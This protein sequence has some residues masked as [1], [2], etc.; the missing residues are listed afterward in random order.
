MIKYRVDNNTNNKKYGIQD[1]ILKGAHLKNIGAISDNKYLF[2][3]GISDFNVIKYDI[4]KQIGDISFT[5]TVHDNSNNLRVVIDYISDEPITL[6]Q[7]ESILGIL[8]ECKKTMELIDKPIRINI[9][10]KL[11]PNTHKDFIVMCPYS[12]K[13]AY[14]FEKE[15]YNL[16]D[17]DNAIQVIDDEREKLVPPIEK[18]LNNEKE[19]VLS[20]FSFIRKQK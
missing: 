12:L 11:V 17:V 16:M 8:N 3:V 15:F 18:K 6:F 1:M 10:M 5:F 2:E 9:P 14:E 4:E 13:N 19:K 7:Y 20:L